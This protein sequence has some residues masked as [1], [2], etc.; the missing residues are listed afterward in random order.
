M[1]NKS[2]V[3]YVWEQTV[4]ATW[5]NI[6]YIVLALP[7]ILVMMWALLSPYDSVQSKVLLVITVS[8][9]TMMVLLLVFI[10]YWWWQDKRREYEMYLKSQMELQEMER[11]W[12]ARTVSPEPAPPADE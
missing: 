3:R 6:K 11:R 1:K 2:F 5:N 7:L 4:V 10:P 12:E 9:A 8:T